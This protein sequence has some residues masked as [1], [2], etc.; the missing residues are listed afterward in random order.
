MA[1]TIE[2]IYFG[3]CPNV[4]DARANLRVVLAELGLPIEWHEWTQEDS[5]APQRIMAYGSPTVLVNGSDVTGSSAGVA[6]AACRVDGA[7]SAGA[8][9]SALTRGT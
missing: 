1:P 9:R 4:E 6:A 3:G 5:G 8:I 7:P 2:L